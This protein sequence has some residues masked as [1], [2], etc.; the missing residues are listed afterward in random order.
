MG[1]DV[2]DFSTRRLRRRIR[3][4]CTLVD[5]AADDRAKDTDYPK[6]SDIASRLQVEIDCVLIGC[7]LDPNDFRDA[8]LSEVYAGIVD[9]ID[10]LWRRVAADPSVA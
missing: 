6:Y 10:D 3:S 5:P 1:D 4:F 9:K 2:I 8:E 7:G